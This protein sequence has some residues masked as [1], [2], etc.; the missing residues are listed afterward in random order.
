RIGV[1]PSE[2]REA[3]RIAG[4]AGLKVNGIHF[5]RGTGTNLTA[6]FIES[7]PMVLEAGRVLPDWEYL[8]FG[9][10]FGHPYRADRPAFDWPAFGSELSRQVRVLGRPLELI[11]EPGR[12]AI[13]GRG[14]L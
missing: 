3:V 12:A 6:A 13:G 2:F 7:M 8:D 10:G 11:I 14:Q 9:G 4:G 1:R 5:Y